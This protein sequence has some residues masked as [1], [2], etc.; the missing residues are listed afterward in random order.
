MKCIHCKGEMERKTTPFQIDRKGY[1][2]MFDAVL[3]WV[4]SQ[5]GEVYFEENEVDSIQEML[6]TLDEKTENLVVA[7]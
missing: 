3:A 5:C 4:C 7:V 2:L 6:K 1:H